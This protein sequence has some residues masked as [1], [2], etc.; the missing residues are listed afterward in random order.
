[1]EM[2]CPVDASGKFTAEVSH[3][4]GMYIKVSDIIVHHIHVYCVRQGALNPLWT[5]NP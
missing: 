2:V 1:M 3:F 5:G 4:K